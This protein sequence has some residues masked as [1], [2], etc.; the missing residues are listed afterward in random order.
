[1]KR[2]Y[3]QPEVQVTLLA[4]MPVMQITSPVVPDNGAGKMNDLPTNDQW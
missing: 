2:N 3:K 4:S 1:M